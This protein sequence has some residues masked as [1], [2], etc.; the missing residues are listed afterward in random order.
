M[1]TNVC[2]YSSAGFLT[3]SRTERSFTVSEIRHFTAT[4]NRNRAESSVLLPS[5]VESLKLVSPLT[6]SSISDW[7]RWLWSEVCSVAPH[8]TMMSQGY[9]GPL[10]HHC[11]KLR[12]KTTRR[13]QKQNFRHL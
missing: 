3:K 13:Q 10:V 11:S 9:R 1:E 5:L 6:T 4:L 2:V 7:C 12:N 8:P